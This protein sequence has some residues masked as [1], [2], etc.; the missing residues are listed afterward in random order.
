MAHILVVD[1][2]IGIRELLSE[3]LEDEGHSI[4]LAENATAA[5]RIRTEKRPDLVLLDIWMPDTDGISL[6]KE[7]GAS[8]LLTMPVV[9]M[10]GHGTIDTAVEATRHGAVEFLEKPIALQKLLATVKKALKHDA[11]AAKPPLTL[12]ALAKSPLLKD[13]KKRLEQAAKSAPVLLLKGGAGAIAEICARTLQAPHSPWLDLA[14]ESG[15]LTQERLEQAAGGVIFVSDLAHL[16]KLQQMNLAFALERL[17]KYK[18]LLV[19]ASH[20][21]LGALLEAGWDPALAARL[22]EVWV[23]L[24]QLS[25]HADEVPEIAALLLTHLMERGEAPARH[26]S[27]AALNALRMHR[28]G[29]DG[30]GELQGAVKNL[31]L[32]ALEEEISAEDVAGLL[33]SAAPET[34][35]TPLEPLFAQPLREAR[36]AFEKLYFD[37]LLRQEGGNMT[38]VSERSGVERTHLYRKLKQLGVSTGKR[39][40][41][42]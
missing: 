7:W 23:A 40:A 22:G 26:F 32:T 33:S 37:H 27:S 5:R 8:G 24:P 21:P 42:G 2:E 4:S 6:L 25:T 18:L 12:D 10:S 15:P 30:W 14:G 31:A 38:R 19:V 16:G 11:Q 34:V 9:M 13:L 41:E 20:K 35:A 29:A 28:W 3:I 17:E 36:D 39:G 1:D